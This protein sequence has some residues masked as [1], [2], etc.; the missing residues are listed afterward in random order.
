[1]KEC[2]GNFSED[3]YSRGI[4]DKGTGPVTTKKMKGNDGT[5]V[6]VICITYGHE[7][8][9]AQA[10]DSFL[11][12]KT[13]FKF[14]VF[15]GED[16]GPDHTADIVREYAAKYPDIIVPF[17]REKNMG[18]Q[19]NLID[20]CQRAT[21]PYLAFCEGDDYWIDD[22]KLQKQFD[23]MEAHKEIPVC[24]TK[25]RVDAP[26]DWHLRNWYREN[27]RHEIIIPDGIPGFKEKANGL[28][29]PAERLKIHI[30]H[31]STFFFR[32]N[33][34]LKFEDW[35]FEGFSGDEPLLMMQ[36]GISH[37]GLLP[38]V[39]SVYRINSNSTFFWS[40]SEQK[41]FFLKTRI[42]GYIHWMSHFWEFANENFPTYPLIAIENLIKQESAN[43]LNACV[44]LKRTDLISEFFAKYPEAG[45]I[46]L[47]AYLSFYR[48][49]RQM[50]NSWT[51]EGY[52]L[53]ARNR[54]Y[55][56]AL[57]PYVKLIRGIE[58]IRRQIRAKL[59][60]LI[61]FICYWGFTAVPKK[62]NLWVFSA[63][64][65]KGYM[66]NSRY[67]Y[68]WVTERHP[69]IEAY[70]VT[71]DDEVYRNLREKGKPVL[72]M[73]TWMCIKKLC[74]AEIA[75]TDHFVMSDYD[76]FSGFNDRIKVVQ[77]WHGVGLK[78]IGHLENTDVNGVMFSEDILPLPGDGFRTRLLKKL[79]YFRHAY[80]REKFE[81][82]FMLVCPGE[83]RA[84]QIADPW[85][86]PRERCFF[87]GHP[88]NR[89]LH[90]IKPDP[91]GPVKILYAPTY[92]WN[93]QKEQE[94]IQNLIDSFAVIE[95]CM[96]E[97][98]GQFVIRLHP[99][100]WRNYSAQ[101][102]AALADYPRIVYDLEK[103]IYTTLGT[104]SVM[105]SDY[106]SIAYDFV[107]LDRPIIFYCPDLE[108]F[109]KNEDV[110]NYDYMEYSPGPKTKT[111]TETTEQ[112]RAYVRDPKKDSPWRIKVRDEFYRMDVN[113]ENNS[114]RIVQEVERRLGMG[115]DK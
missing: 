58:K 88:R 69:E 68:E 42:P 59:R 89:Y 28:Y 75:F 85:H 20:L 92:R 39:S 84:L 14:K 76:N 31:T 21:S 77:L 115:R 79:K 56:N 17:I 41:I 96:E 64:C 53:V 97:I 29:T 18:A 10:L 70:W 91:S 78:A 54:W 107:L 108:A 98:N 43:Y 48:D 12:Q 13:N 30:G 57:R 40:G 74:R 46:S 101:I 95:R 67:L 26:K 15:V 104:Y 19:R 86:I 2:K 34:D 55:R 36:L 103:D 37:L 7:K 23:Y 62:K 106:S 113:D 90:M 114:E 87:S 8:F 32:W 61:S 47:N 35:Y 49:S 51:W 4:N 109:M 22:Q 50:T 112:V 44:A 83:E 9:I 81:R 38:I 82:Y 52:Q 45:R 63:F 11:M 71:M 3:S 80:F 33:Y 105:I 16:C 72:K 65:K 100:T 25:T 102:Q 5:A 6:T 110:L 66:D 111:W 73:R 24:V 1:M 27:A 60:N 99:H 93:A 94:M